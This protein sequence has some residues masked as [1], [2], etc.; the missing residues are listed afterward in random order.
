MSTT[1]PIYRAGRQPDFD[2]ILRVLQRQRPARATLFE[3]AIDHELLAQLAGMPLRAR[4]DRQ[5]GLQRQ[6][7]AFYNAGYDY[8]IF[9]E[10]DFGFPIAETRHA[11]S[12]SLNEGFVIT[13]RASFAAYPW[14]DPADFD[15][16]PL[17]QIAAE[18]P[19]GMKVISTGP[20]GVL[21]N[22][23]RLLGFENLC[24]LLLDDPELVRDVCDAV[25]SRM[26]KHY[27]LTAALP[28]VGACISSD[29][30][31]F[32][33]QSMLSPAD[34]RRYI[35]PWHARIVSAIHA[36]GKPAILHS[37]GNLALLLEELLDDYID[38]LR[39]RDLAIWDKDSSKAQYVRKL[40]RKIPQSFEVYR[41]FVETRPPEVV[42]NIAICLINQTNYLIDHQLRR[43]E[44]DFLEQGGLRERMTRMRLQY[45]NSTNAPHDPQMPPPKRRGD[46]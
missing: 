45:R 13:D 8:A 15:Y 22:V 9:G 2:N 4:E 1:T 24:L 6:V 38:F 30:W 42:A 29:D 5:A 10:W 33:T 20:Y 19:A 21:E 32:K 39:A 35:F 31:G 28:A 41:E 14:A 46:K 12:I 3:M 17:E 18:L 40:G 26:L 23:I 27:Q 44:K 16:S 25:G 11:A 7:L 43:L 34:M 37:C 36:C